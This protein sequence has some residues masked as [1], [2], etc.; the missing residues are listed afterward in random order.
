MKNKKEFLTTRMI[1]LWIKEKATSE[2]WDRYESV[3]IIFTN[4]LFQNEIGDWSGRETAMGKPSNGLERTNYW[5]IL[6]SDI[7][8]AKAELEKIVKNYQLIHVT[9]IEMSKEPDIEDKKNYK[10]IFKKKKEFTWTYYKNKKLLY[11]RSVKI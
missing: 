10:D 1:D 9:K 5:I 7:D 6:N 2:E 8:K 3:L 11:D 4:F